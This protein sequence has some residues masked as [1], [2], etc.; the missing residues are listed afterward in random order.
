MLQGIGK[1]ASSEFRGLHRGI[2]EQDLLG[3]ARVLLR[4]A[5]MAAF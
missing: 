5:A 1:G 4:G 2:R 3:E